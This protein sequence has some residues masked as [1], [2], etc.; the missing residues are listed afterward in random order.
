MTGWTVSGPWRA[1]PPTCQ[2]ANLPS[3]DQEE[4][5]PSSSLKD[6]NDEDDDDEELRVHVDVDGPQGD[7]NVS[8]RE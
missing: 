4:E 3:A 1:E 2:H 7:E 5:G 6:E 8:I